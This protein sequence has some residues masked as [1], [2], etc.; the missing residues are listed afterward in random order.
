MN[1][2]GDTMNGYVL[3]PPKLDQSF[4]RRTFPFNKRLSQAQFGIPC[5]DWS[6]TR[7]PYEFKAKFKIYMSFNA[8]SWFGIG[9]GL[10]KE[11]GFPGYT[12]NGWMFCTDGG[13]HHNSAAFLP[14]I[15]IQFNE[16]IK[17]SCDPAN[18]RISIKTIAGKRHFKCNI[19]NS[20]YFYASLYN[21]AVRIWSV[22]ARC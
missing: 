5:A 13:T 10:V 12:A 4:S 6:N 17:F 21:S 14:G 15:S 19:P 2:S 7:L 18:Y 20:L 9:N 8:R 22:H 11:T 16:I 3:L 1:I